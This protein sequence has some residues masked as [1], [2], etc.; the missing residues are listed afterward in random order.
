MAVVVVDFEVELSSLM[1]INRNKKNIQG[2]GKHFNDVQTGDVMGYA[3][4]SA[5]P[6][7]FAGRSHA[8]SIAQI[9]LGIGP[10]I[11]GWLGWDGEWN[12]GLY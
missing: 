12:D 9:A 2:K 6:R 3:V 8:R 11:D 5:L 7:R 10:R 4:R 1:K